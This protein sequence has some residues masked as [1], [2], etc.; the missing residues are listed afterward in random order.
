MPASGCI[1]AVGARRPRG[2]SIR[3]A[4][5]A[6]ISFNRDYLRS[7]ICLAQGDF[8]SASAGLWLAKDCLT[9]QRCD[10]SSHRGSLSR[11]T[12]ANGRAVLSAVRK[13]I[14]ENLPEIVFT[15]LD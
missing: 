14:N 1:V 13:V 4:P 15:P 12:P 5:V 2:F 10:I 11:R 8:I 7:F 6:A 3:L 9:R